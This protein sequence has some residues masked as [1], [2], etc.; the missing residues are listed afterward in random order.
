MSA[1]P[2]SDALLD[3]SVVPCPPELQPE[4]AEAFAMRLERLYE[5]IVACR[6]IA[7]ELG[8]AGCATRLA[9]LAERLSD[10]MFDFDRRGR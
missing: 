10:T 7:T 8:A 1:T 5:E 4:I 3:G 2:I 6:R 9:H